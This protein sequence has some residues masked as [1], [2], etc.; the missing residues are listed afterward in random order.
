MLLPTTSPTDAAVQRPRA[1]ILEFFADAILS[2]TPLLLPESLRFELLAEPAKLLES[3]L[4]ERVG[5]D[6]A[7][8]QRPGPLNDAPRHR[9]ERDRPSFGDQHLCIVSRQLD[10]V[11]LAVV[12]HVDTVEIVRQFPDEFN[13]QPVGVRHRRLPRKGTEDP[14]GRQ[15]MTAAGEMPGAW[16]PGA[17]CESNSRT[18]STR[19]RLRSVSRL[20]G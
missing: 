19:I 6:D 3:P 8:R 5:G 1:R 7:V 13:S 10:D 12:R 20:R 17:P 11:A 16:R 2:A 14:Q 18:A 4:F 9:V 15:Y